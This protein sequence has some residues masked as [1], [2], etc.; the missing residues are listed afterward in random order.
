M[1]PHRTYSRKTT[2]NKSTFFAA[3]SRSSNNKYRKLTNGVKVSTLDIAEAQSSDNSINVTVNDTFDRLQKGEKY[4]PVKLKERAKYFSSE[5]DPSKLQV[6]YC[7][8]IRSP[9]IQRRR[10]R[11]K[12]TAKKILISSSE[13]LREK[14]TFDSSVHYNLEIQKCNDK[15]VLRHYSTTISESKA[16]VSYELIFK[17]S[18]CVRMLDAPKVCSTP[19]STTTVPLNATTEISPI[20]TKSRKFRWEQ[21]VSSQEIEKGRTGKKEE[22]FSRKSDL[23]MDE[24]ER[25]A[26][27]LKEESDSLSPFAGFADM[28][29][30]ASV[31]RFYFSKSESYFPKMGGIENEL[32][33][34]SPKKKEDC[35]R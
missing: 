29:Q 15:S 25:K 6:S 35:Q 28:E 7:T 1:V 23:R 4:Q 14:R 9:I 8:T 3:Q 31:Q 18:F 5:S 20:S 24:V 27:D 16:N 10:K 17:K 11:K 19:I 2:T 34:V 33:E 26:V 21:K 30:S 12:V 32:K 13:G 22:E